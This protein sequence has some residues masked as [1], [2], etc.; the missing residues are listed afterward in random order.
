MRLDNATLESAK[1][2]PLIFYYDPTVFRSI[3]HI[4]SI[5]HLPNLPLRNTFIVHLAGFFV[6]RFKGEYIKSKVLITTNN[7]LLTI[8]LHSSL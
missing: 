1:L 4:A 5:V 6:Y 3:L 7:S 2:P 8:Y